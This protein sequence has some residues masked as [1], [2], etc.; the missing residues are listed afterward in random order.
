M[1]EILTVC[2]NNQTHTLLGV[3]DG[4]TILETIWRLYGESSVYIP[5]DVA[6]PFLSILPTPPK[7][8]QTLFTKD[9]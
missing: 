7:W 9:F 5:Y 3:E 6:I 4:I 2:G 1:L 8:K